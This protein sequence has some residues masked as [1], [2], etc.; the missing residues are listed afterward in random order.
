MAIISIADTDETVDLLIEAVKALCKWA[1][2]TRPNSYVDLPHHRELGT[3]MIMPPT[4]A[5]FSA[6]RKVSI[7]DA[8]G[9]IIA[10]MVSPYPPGIPRLWPGELITPAIIEYLKKGRD[11]GMFVLDPSDQK[12]KTLRV[13][14]LQANK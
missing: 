6:T 2:A 3:K 12:L 9:E 10:E 13:V 7:D 8:E 1:K 5:F 14:D 4:R 11:A